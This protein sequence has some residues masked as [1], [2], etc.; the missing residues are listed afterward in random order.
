MKRS[1]HACGTEPSL[2]FH[3]VRGVAQLKRAAILSALAS[4]TASFH[5]V[6]GVAQ[7]KRTAGASC[8]GPSSPPF[9]PRSRGGPIEARSRLPREA[10]RHRTFHPVRGVAQLKRRAQADPIPGGPRP[11]HP[12]RGVAQLKRADRPACCRRSPPFP[13]RSRGGPIEAR[14]A[15]LHSGS[16]SPFPPRSRGG[17]IEARIHRLNTLKSAA[18]FH[19]VRGVAQL[20]RIRCAFHTC[21]RPRLSTPFAGWPN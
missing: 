7:L 16:E 2:S 12:V 14:G 11:F 6:R 3:P 4:A 17:P 10:H 18:A 20:K 1:E 15:G 5:P 13:P 19:P 9:P 21:R 8:I